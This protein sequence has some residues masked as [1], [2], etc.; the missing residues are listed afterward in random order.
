MINSISIVFSDLDGTLL[1][2]QRTIS[3]NTLRCLQDMAAR[4]ITRVIATGRSY[5]SFTKIAGHTFPADYLICSSGAG[6]FDL[7]TDELLH[8]RHLGSND[9]QSIA[10]RLIDLGIDFTV[11]TQ[12]PDNHHFTYY[13]P[14]K[15]NRDFAHRLQLYEAYATPFSG[16]AGLPKRSAQ[17]IAVLPGNAERFTEIAG[18]FKEYQVTRTTSPLNH[19]SIWLEI[20]PKDVTKGSGARWLC[21]FLDLPEERSFG[22]GND[23]NDI[24]LLNF[25]ALSYVVANAPAELQQR[26]S[27]TRS[28]DEDGLSHIWNQFTGSPPSPD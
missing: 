6:I 5:Y 15:D 22:I 21:S 3:L 19:R 11:H 14:N 7:R 16:V 13:F 12:V 18:Y 4:G 20:Y 24:D 2:S 8:A 10:Q 1:N 28:N 25:T 27:L 17:I 26:Y 9:V 23:Y